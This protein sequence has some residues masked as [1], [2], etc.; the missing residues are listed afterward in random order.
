MQTIHTYIENR[1]VKVLLFQRIFEYPKSSFKLLSR[2]RFENSSLENCMN[3]ISAMGI[4][5]IAE[6]S[7]KH[8]LNP[9]VE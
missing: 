8:I 2:L 5:R 9:Y 7:I 3:G 4:R 6:T 1:V